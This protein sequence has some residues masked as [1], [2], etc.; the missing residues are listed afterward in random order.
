M[1]KVTARRNCDTDAVV[2]IGTSNDET[3]VACTPQ[4]KAFKK[5]RTKK[6]AVT[7]QSGDVDNEGQNIA[8]AKQDVDSTL[9][10]VAEGAGHMRA[11]EDVGVAVLVDV[12]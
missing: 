9:V 12:G 4:K 11:N 1:V 5:K 8:A 2:G 10:R 6:S 7:I 3:N